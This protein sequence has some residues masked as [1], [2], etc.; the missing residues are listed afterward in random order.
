MPVTLEKNG[1][2]VWID[3]LLKKAGSWKRDKMTKVKV[4]SGVTK[5]APSSI[6]D[7]KQQLSRTCRAINHLNIGG[8]WMDNIFIL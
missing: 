4:L 7:W 3:K 2:K 1:T 8:G 5:Y 6:P